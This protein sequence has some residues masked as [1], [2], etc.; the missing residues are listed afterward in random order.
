MNPEK[1]Y[2][3]SQTQ[4]SIAAYYGGCTYNGSRY[5]YNPIDDTLTKED[6]LKGKVSKKIKALS[7]SE[8]HGQKELFE[9]IKKRVDE[10]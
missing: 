9:E 3:I 7:Q 1:I 5:V 4:L 6:V 2:N 8:W 10:K